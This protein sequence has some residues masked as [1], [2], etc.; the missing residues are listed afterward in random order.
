MHIYNA[1]LIT[2]IN[3]VSPLETCGKA[4]KLDVL[5]FPEIGKWYF[6]YTTCVPL[7]REFDRFCLRPTAK[8]S[9]EGQEST[10]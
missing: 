8:L 7:I 6:S 1:M 3:F 2:N 5:L 10:F 4:L 9:A